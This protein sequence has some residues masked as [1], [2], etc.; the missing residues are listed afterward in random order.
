MC[1]RWMGVCVGV[2]G[3]GW[4]C[5]GRCVWVCVGMGVCVCVLF[6]MHLTDEIA[7]LNIFVIYLYIVTQ[8]GERSDY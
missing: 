6:I 5:V 4:V 7:T 1:V 3:G 8:C 2:C